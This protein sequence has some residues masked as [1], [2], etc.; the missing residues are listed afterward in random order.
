[1]LTGI[2]Q[3]ILVICAVITSGKT[4]LHNMMNAFHYFSKIIRNFNNYVNF[5]EI[6]KDN[7]EKHQN[8]IIRDVI[9]GDCKYII[10]G[11]AKS[12]KLVVVGFN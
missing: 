6:N 2:F 3:E 12:L 9:A 10:I 8:K 1:M 5:P 4:F 7:L 11:Y